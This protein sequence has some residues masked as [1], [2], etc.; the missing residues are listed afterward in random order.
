M[1]EMYGIERCPDKQATAKIKVK[2]R[3]IGEK[4]YRVEGVMSP[5]RQDRLDHGSSSQSEITLN[6]ERR[7]D[8]IKT[9]DLIK[10]QVSTWKN[11]VSEY[12]SKFKSEKME[13]N[14]LNELLKGKEEI[15]LSLKS[16][17]K[18]KQI[19]VQTVLKTLEEYKLQYV[20]VR[21]ECEMVKKERDR[22]Q[23]MVENIERLSQDRMNKL[24]NEASGNIK[25]I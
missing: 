25:K 7:N 22:F 13:N 15:Y 2:F 6:R 10:Q 24:E 23:I 17:I 9:T 19:Q 18:R 20:R 3:C 8:S 14:K 4:G 5:T 16:E 12:E 1:K 11:R 21:N